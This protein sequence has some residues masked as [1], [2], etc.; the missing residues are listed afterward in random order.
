MIV[1]TIPNSR[2]TVIYDA[3]VSSCCKQRKAAPA[4]RARQPPRQTHADPRNLVARSMEATI[5]KVIST[6]DGQKRPHA[7]ER[8]QWALSAV[9][10]RSARD[11]CLSSGDRVSDPPHLADCDGPPRAAGRRNTARSVHKHRFVLHFTA[12]S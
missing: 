4:L 8:G 5:N 3:T 12:L 6:L 10:C 1:A 2:S 11:G 9:C 7:R